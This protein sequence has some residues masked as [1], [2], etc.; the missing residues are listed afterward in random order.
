MT[1][2]MFTGCG[3]L[4]EGGLTDSSNHT[5]IWPFEFAAYRSNSLL[6]QRRAAPMPRV[7][8]SVSER[9]WRVPK[10]TRVST[11]ERIFAGEISE[12]ISLTRGFFSCGSCADA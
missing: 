8:L 5:F 9:V 11:L 4:G 7:L 1:L 2:T 12:R 10:P 6:I 3:I